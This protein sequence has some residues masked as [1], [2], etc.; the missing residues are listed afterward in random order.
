MSEQWIEEAANEIRT[1]CSK[2]SHSPAQAGD[3][4][5]IIERHFDVWIETQPKDDTADLAARIAS[6]QT[7]NERLQRRLALLKHFARQASTFAGKIADMAHGALI[8]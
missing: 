6:L 7:E 8:E 1:W 5:E 3:I 2:I 4:S